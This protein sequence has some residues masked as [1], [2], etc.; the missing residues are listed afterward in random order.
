MSARW[1]NGTWEGFISING[2]KQNVAMQLHFNDSLIV[3]GNGVNDLFGYFTVEGSYSNKP[4][5]SC[6]LNVKFSSGPKITLTGWREQE[7][8]GMV[9]NWTGSIEGS[10]SG[11]FSLAPNKDQS[12]ISFSDNKKSQ[13]LSLGFSEEA[14]NKVLTQTDNIDEAITLLT[15]GGMSGSQIAHNNEPGENEIIQLVSLGFDADKARMALMQ[16]NNN[17]EQAAN[18]LFAE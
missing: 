6:E 15:E 9:G 14:I 5:Y 18:L 17:V 7:R 4:P 10:G 11:S 13:L 1:R 2:K 8:N 3:G 12:S 16:T